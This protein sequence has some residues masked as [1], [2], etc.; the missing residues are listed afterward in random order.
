MYGSVA[1]TGIEFSGASLYWRRLN[2]VPIGRGFACQDHLLSP[3]SMKVVIRHFG[4]IDRERRADRWGGSFL[5]EG[6]SAIGASRERSTALP[7]SIPVRLV[8]KT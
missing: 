2:V 5:L 6:D 8:V 3:P 4:G 1:A 7:G